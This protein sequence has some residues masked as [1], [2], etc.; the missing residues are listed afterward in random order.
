MPDLDTRPDLVQNLDTR[1]ELGQNLD[2][3]PE[4]C[5]NPLD[6]RPD[7]WPINK[8]GPIRAKTYMDYSIVIYQ[9]FYLGTRHESRYKDFLRPIST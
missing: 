5:Q 9:A 2:T 6:T 1:P 7:F 4:L 8:D 3:R